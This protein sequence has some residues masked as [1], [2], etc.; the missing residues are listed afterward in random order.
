MT[1]QDFRPTAE[2]GSNWAARPSGPDRP[3]PAQQG[4]VRANELFLLG[5]AGQPRK[6]NGLGGPK[7]LSGGPAQQHCF[8]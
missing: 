5:R 6:T 3:G 4:P 7:I 1:S 2:Q 8:Y